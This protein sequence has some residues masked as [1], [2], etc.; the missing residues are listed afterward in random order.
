MTYTEAETEELTDLK[1]ERCTGPYS[2]CIY[3]RYMR[4]TI[5]PMMASGS[6]IIC[7]AGKQGGH[8]HALGSLLWSLLVLMKVPPW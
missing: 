7:D 6:L 8:I 5:H 3:G 1:K 2:M 4:S